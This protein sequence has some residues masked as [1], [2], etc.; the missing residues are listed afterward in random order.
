MQDASGLEARG[1][2]CFI[3]PFGRLLSAFLSSGT[4]RGGEA[5]KALWRKEI[6]TLFLCLKT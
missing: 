4:A 1:L 5:S 3:I 6:E 2:F